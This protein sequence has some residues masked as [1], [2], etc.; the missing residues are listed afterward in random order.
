MADTRYELLHI[1]YRARRASATARANRIS[2]LVDLARLASAAESRDW[3]VEVSVMQSEGDAC[4][5]TVGTYT[6]YGASLS[7][8]ERA[9]TSLVLKQDQPEIVHL[10]IM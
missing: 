4:H 8:T 7:L 10:C 5:M 3:M 2:G 1:Q 9:K 6:E